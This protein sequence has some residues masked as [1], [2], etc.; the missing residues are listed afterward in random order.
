MLAIEGGVAAG[1]TAFFKR[2]AKCY[3]NVKFVPEP[4]NMWTDIRKGHEDC[5]DIELENEDAQDLAKVDDRFNLLKLRFEDPQRFSFSFQL[6]VLITRIEAVQ[7]AIAEATEDEEID[8]VFIERSWESNRLFAEILYEEN[9]FSEIERAMYENWFRFLATRAPAVHGHIFICNHRDVVVDRV[10]FR[11]R[12]EEKFLNEYYI[13]RLLHKYEDWKEQMD[14][15]NRDYCEVTGNMD[16]ITDP[17]SW[18]HVSRNLQ[19]YTKRVTGRKLE[20]NPDY[21]M[22]EGLTGPQRVWW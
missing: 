3:T 1:K 9:Q 7:M 2:M 17:Y 21:N 8:F 19:Q 14:K 16:L 11:K 15:L 20:R 13:D 5:I 10:S 4:R 22:L 6:W 18:E 12:R